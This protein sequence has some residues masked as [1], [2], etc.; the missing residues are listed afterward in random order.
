MNLPS[1]EMGNPDT[2]V[3]GG[4]QIKE[5]FFCLHFCH[6]AAVTRLNFTVYS[7]VDRRA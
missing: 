3:L 5:G 1:Y 7:P 6:G 4:W 2:K